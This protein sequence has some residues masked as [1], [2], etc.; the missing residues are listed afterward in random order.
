M[1]ERRWTEEQLSAINTRNKTLLVSAAAG[2]GKT[3][4]LTE[5]IIR[6]LTDEENPQ[7]IEGLL[8]VTYTTAAAAELRAKLSKALS[9]AV[10]KNPENKRLERQLF[11]LPSAKISTI[12]S[13]LGEI[14]RQN[15]DRVGIT[16]NYRIAEGA[17]CELLATGILGGMISSVYRGELS[18]VGT[19]EEFEE[20]AEALTSSK[21]TEDLLD[22]FR[23]IRAKCE[24]DEDGVGILLPL[25]ERYNPELFTSPEK[26]F[27]GSYI[28][29]R[30]HEF[31]SHYI[32]AISKYEQA[33]LF[34]NKTE[35]KYLKVLLSDKNKL[36]SIK[37]A[38]TY[39]EMREA[40]ISPY[41]SLPTGKLEKTEQTISY[42][43]TRARMKSEGE[44]LSECFL[45]PEELWKPL[46]SGLYKS[47]SVLYRFVS[48][49]EK[50]LLEEKISRGALGFSDV[51]RLAYSIL[52]SNGE[53]NDIALNLRRRFSSIYID[54]YQDINRLQNCIFGAISRE[55]NCFMVGDIK[56]SI[57]SFRL[58]RPEIFAQLK[59]EYPPLSRSENSPRASV[60][61]SS[62]FRCDEPIIDFVNSVFDKT[63]S[64]MGESLGYT[65][66][67]R[68]RF[69]KPL[70]DGEKKGDF[71]PEICLTEGKAS[72]SKQNPN[73]P[74]KISTAKITARKIKELLS[75]G[76]RND[77][78][79]I[80]PS[81]IAIL[82]R[83]KTRSRE[84]S[85][86]LSELGI[87][88]EISG[89]GDFFLS[90]EVLLVLSA[91][92]SI[93]NPR[94]DIYLAGLMCSPLFSFSAD[95]LYEIRSAGGETLYDS[96][97]IYCSQ[98]PSYE[99]GAHFLERLS[100]Y[101]KISEGVGVDVLIYKL[102]HETGL[103]A[104]ASKSGGKENLLLLY[105]Y[106]RGYE[107][108]AY[109][110]LYNFINFINKLI[111]NKTERDTAF[112]NEREE[113]SENCVK[114]LS[115]HKSKGLE[116]PVVFLVEAGQGF[117][118][119]D[120]MP[121]LLFSEGFGLSL[122]LR[123]P[124]GLAIAENPVH[125]IMKHYI[126][127]KSYEEELRILY[128]ALTRARE[129]LFIVGS[130]PS[131]DRDK[132]LDKI[133][134]L[135]EELSPYSVRELSS[136]LEIIL[137]T[138][139]SAS[140]KDYGDFL[141]SPVAREEISESDFSYEKLAQEAEKEESESEKTK[142]GEKGGQEEPTEPI[143]ED[144]E[145]TKL[146]IER[147]SY[148]YPKSALTLLPEKLSVSVTSPTILDGV[149]A[150]DF[151]LP[152][153]SE[154]VSFQTKN[155]NKK[156]TLPKFAEGREEEE[157]AKRGIATHYFMQFFNI[158]NL[159]N[160]GAERELLRLC[161]EG[162]LSERDKE[163][164]RL[165][166]L[167]L[168]ERSKLLTDMKG[169]SKIY[170]ELRFNVY[171]PATLFTENEELKS[172][173]CNEEI[174]VQGVIDCILIDNDGNVSVYDYKTDRLTKEELIY[175]PLAEK[176]LIGRHKVQLSYYAMAVEKMFGKKPIRV[177]VYSLPLGDTVD[178]N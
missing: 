110:G 101:R 13:F 140:V 92:N 75:E 90:P 126:D 79:P 55:D 127:R 85:E 176:K 165:D 159:I 171:L 56:Q 167:A 16:P 9:E 64:L 58:A 131:Y 96:L 62:N 39:R 118:N 47:L 4:T 147:F 158:D 68:L 148:K 38:E 25:I 123:T 146:F 37:N 125:S 93:D 52:V 19:A 73:P 113:G 163:R 72:R 136:Y 98:N 82:M 48:L 170:R 164:V 1:G 137:T 74:P 78:E 100:Y 103:Y 120:K 17:E 87:S 95:E 36:L 24:C 28:M 76:K 173:L 111:D 138:Q 175:R 32:S 86:A 27:H 144:T 89:D 129:R 154:D 81:D 97:K 12:D 94:R 50:T 112:D 151:V 153:L 114:I 132:Y 60:F 172:E 15:C 61:M 160:I 40:I 59:Q 174:L 116:Y 26:T 91:L 162:F 150:G 80:L 109:K 156:R 128:V 105:D 43:D 5:R 29:E 133:S 141:S 70:G 178:V 166:E 34:G 106:A 134:S 67:D 149:D 66:D 135:R 21:R 99:R 20:L 31:A 53:P 46:F 115:C 14:L 119:Q 130:A 88:S 83:S 63:F 6:S 122:R 121:R 30:A 117:S 71:I 142:N 11:M 7:D 3:A 145:L 51:A 107:A 152:E 44:A 57:Y 23:L 45:Y 41:E 42:A 104:L 8:V 18:E 143:S 108:G 157:S 33:F 139:S 168:F 54:E 10:E 84:Y 2:S 65:S 161:K 169:A 155:E 22:V 69:A 102:Y 177:A 77:G 35:E 124:S 49:F